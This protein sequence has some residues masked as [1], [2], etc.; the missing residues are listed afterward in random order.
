[1]MAEIVPGSDTGETIT[2]LP[3]GKSSAAKATNKAA[4]PVATA[5]VRPPPIRRANASM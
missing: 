1:M 5:S 2:S 3:G 4:V